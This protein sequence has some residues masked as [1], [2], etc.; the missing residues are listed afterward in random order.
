[1]CNTGWP[2]LKI[3]ASHS[4]LLCYAELT[5][6]PLN[7]LVYE[8]EMAQ[9]HQLNLWFCSS[10]IQVWLSVQLSDLAMVE[11]KIQEEVL[12]ITFAIHVW[13]WIIAT[14]ALDN[15]MWWRIWK[16]LKIKFALIWKKLKTH[17][18]QHALKTYYVV[19]HPLLKSVNQSLA[20]CIK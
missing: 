14:S 10:E 11:K 4:W 16:I 9:P 17:S 15:G 3:R 6:L 13:N 1:M 7:D 18:L 5:K 19:Y 8:P 12:F 20:M 2:D